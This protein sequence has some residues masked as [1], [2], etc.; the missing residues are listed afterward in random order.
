MR[1]RKS[2][3]QSEGAVGAVVIGKGHSNQMQEWKYRTDQD[4][5]AEVEVGFGVV[6]E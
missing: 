3:P 6:L 5:M 2:K 1:P 4:R